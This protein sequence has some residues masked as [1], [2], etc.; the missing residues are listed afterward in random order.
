MTPQKCSLCGKCIEKCPFGALTM[1]DKGIVVNDKCRA[2]GLCVRTCPESAIYFEQKADT[3]D[4]DAWKDFLIFV[5][6][7]RGDIHPVA[8]ELIGE[9][10]E[11]GFQSR[12]QGQLCHHWA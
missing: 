1:E 3:F 8:Y 5:E 6:Q 10:T 11:N 9:A 12:L 2:C 4:K 7:E